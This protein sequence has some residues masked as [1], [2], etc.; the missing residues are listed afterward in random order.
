VC[1]RVAGPYSPVVAKFSRQAL[2]RPTLHYA[3]GEDRLYLMFVFRGGVRRGGRAPAAAPIEPLL[4][5]P[6]TGAHGV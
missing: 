3:A 6:I 4:E 2:L 1:W 5:P